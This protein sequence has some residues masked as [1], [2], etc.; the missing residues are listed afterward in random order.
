METL[1]DEDDDVVVYDLVGVFDDDF[2]WR[3]KMINDDSEVKVM[4]LKSYGMEW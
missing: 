4:K 2:V 3:K 1:G